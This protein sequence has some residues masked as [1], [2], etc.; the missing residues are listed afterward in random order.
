MTNKAQEDKLSAI[1]TQAEVARWWMETY[2]PVG[3]RTSLNKYKDMNAASWDLFTYV[4]QG[5]GYDSRS[6]QQW[7]SVA[8]SKSADVDAALAELGHFLPL[9]RPTDGY[10]HVS[11]LEHTL[12]E[13]GMY[14]LREYAP[15]D[16]RLVKTT[17][18]QE[19]TLGR[20][21]SWA[22]ALAYVR[23]NHWVGWE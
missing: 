16:I 12:S 18:G 7:M 17:Y 6:N 22:L 4:H 5:M 19:S 8:L 2:K 1:T 15:E 21:T 14:E 11:I 9:I 23:D 13:Y 10:K 20:F 3:G